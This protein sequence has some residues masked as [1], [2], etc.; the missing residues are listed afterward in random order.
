[1]TTFTNLIVCYRQFRIMDDNRSGDLSLEEFTNGLKDFGL[2]V[3]DEEY[4][5]LFQI[6]DRDGNGTV[7]YDEFLRAIRVYAIESPNCL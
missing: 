1:M 5:S 6:F 3:S 4:K 2:S 7:K